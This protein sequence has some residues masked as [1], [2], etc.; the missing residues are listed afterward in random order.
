MRFSAEVF[1]TEDTAVQLTWRGAPTGPVTITVSDDR[2]TRTLEAIGDGPG[3]LVI[4]DLEADTEYRITASPKGAEVTRPHRVRTLPTLPGAEL[5]RLSTISDIHIGERWFGQL[6]RVFERPEP[7]VAHTVRCASAAIEEWTRW[8][9]LHVVFKGDLVDHGTRAEWDTLA[10]L[11][12]TVPQPWTLMLGNHETMKRD[13]ERA[14]DMLAQMGLPTDPVRTTDL[15]GLRIVL[16]ETAIDDRGHGRVRD[17]AAAVDAVG[18]TNVPCLVVIHH[19]IQRLPVPTFWPP[20]IES[21]NGNQFV[22]ALRRANPKILITSGHSHRHRKRLIDGVPHV[23][24]GSVKDY[25]GVWAGYVVHEGGLR[26]V[27][28][29]VSPTDCL[30][31]TDRTRAVMLGAWKRFS[32]GSL[33]DRCY[34]HRWS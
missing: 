9:A 15:P 19:H 11:L 4:D 8:G 12:A 1:A 16:V 7:A 28:R 2:S 10:A 14:E 24:V 30:E 34:V 32:P 18:E 27:V 3:A 31:W 20:G 21:I 33:R 17:V 13:R 23:E 6:P 26:Q 22:R 25:P 29:R 5:T